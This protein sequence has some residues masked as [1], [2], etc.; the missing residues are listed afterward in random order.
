M[1]IFLRNEVDSEFQK[2]Y[3][4]DS[5]QWREIAS[6]MNLSFLS[7]FTAK[8]SESVWNHCN[9]SY[10]VNLETLKSKGVDA[11]SW[12]YFAVMDELRGGTRT[13]TDL[14]VP[15]P[16]ECWLEEFKRLRRPTLSPNTDKLP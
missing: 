2:S 12:K 8:E 5:N 16:G 10:E 7:D 11:V 14:C 9:I 1:L 13:I 6:Q 15:R 4:E 3:E